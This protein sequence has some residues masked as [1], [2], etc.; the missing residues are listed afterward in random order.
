MKLFSALG[1]YLSLSSGLA[2]GAGAELENAQRRSPASDPNTEKLVDE[3]L[4]VR[5]HIDQKPTKAKVY[6]FKRAVQ[7]KNYKK[8]KL[9]A[10]YYDLY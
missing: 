8:K 3:Y 2:L 5:Q 1:I 4:M 7:K 9:E 6:L 10:E